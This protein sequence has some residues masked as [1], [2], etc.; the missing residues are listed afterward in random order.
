MNKAIFHSKNWF[1][2]SIEEKLQALQ[3]L[4]NEYAQRQG[5]PPAKIELK[6]EAE[7][8]EVNGEVY[9]RLAGLSKSDNTIVI[10]RK[11]LEYTMEDLKSQPELLMNNVFACHTILHE[12]RHAYQ[13]YAIDHPEIHPDKEQ[14]QKWKENDRVYY[15]APDIYYFFQPLER[16]AENFADHETKKIF[17]ELEK[18]FGKDKNFELYEM[19]RE[20]EKDKL[21]LMSMKYFEKDLESTIQLVGEK[22]SQEYLQAEKRKAEFK[23]KLQGLKEKDPIEVLKGLSTDDRDRKSLNEAVQERRELFEQVISKD[24]DYGIER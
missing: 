9:E 13:K 15:Q 8:V 11:L 18:E 3:E 24:R 1:D 21:K 7:K 6:E 20:I 19:K 4:E 22:I 14:V 16:D 10:G 17:Q 5:R 2:A 12:G 23:K